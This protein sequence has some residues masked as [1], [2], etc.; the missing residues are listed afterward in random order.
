MNMRR[1]R[2]SSRFAGTFGLFAVF[3]SGAFAGESNPREGTANQPVVVLGTKVALPFEYRVLERSEWLTSVDGAN[4]SESVEVEALSGTV[5]GRTLRVSAH[6]YSPDAI[7]QGTVQAAV[8]SHA[9]K[10]SSAI[11][12]RSVRPLQIDGFGFYLIDGRLDGGE[13][14]DALQLYGTVNGTTHR[15]VL[16]VDDRSTITPAMIDAFAA[17]R[18]DFE[19]GLRHA[20]ALRDEQTRAYRKGVVETPIGPISLSRGTEARMILSAVV[21]DGGGTPIFRRRAFSIH[22][23]GV[24]T[25]QTLGFVVGCGSERVAETQAFI[26]MDNGD[27]SSSKR[28][29]GDSED[30]SY[31]LRSGPARATFAGLDGQRSSGLWRPSGWRPR[32]YPVVRWAARTDAA[33]LQAE[34]RRYEGSEKIEEVFARQ[35]AA[36]TPVCRLDLTFGAEPAPKAVDAPGESMPVKSAAP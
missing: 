11:G 1:R 7:D 2:A 21:R 3:A 35:L 19:S 10:M 32:Q 20:Y 14:S 22:K 6:H 8:R 16:A 5:A 36:L 24:L 13:Y 17:T 26:A 23:A 12:T 27:D 31:A 34:L 33:S 15:I 25:P 18:I 29:V 28:K 4:V 9:E 30:P